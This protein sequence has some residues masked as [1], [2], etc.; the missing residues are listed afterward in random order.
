MIAPT[1]P[2]TK[3]RAASKPTRRARPTPRIAVAVVLGLVA[4]VVFLAA[5]ADRADKTEVAV[6]KQPI[7]AGSAIT[8]DMV[9]A[10]EVDSDSPLS[11][12]LVSMADVTAGSVVANRSILTGEAISRSATAEGG[13][14]PAQ[15]VMSIPVAPE[16]AAGGDIGVGDQVDVIDTVDGSSRYVL[17]GAEVVG[18]AGSSDSLGGV[19]GFWL[20]VRVDESEA[21][22]VA[23]ALSD[24]NVIVVRS[25]G[26]APAP[27]AAPPVDPGTTAPAAPD[28]SAGGG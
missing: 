7:G 5:T 27:P 8:P 20:S 2:E 22:A 6:A 16:N 19:E 28:T 17:T 13:G 18:R 1:A 4:F 23:A 12:S 25:T 10:V 26:V 9:T 3:T 15:R 14:A 21:L 24:G 11:D